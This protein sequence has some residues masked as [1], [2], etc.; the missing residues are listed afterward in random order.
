MIKTDK[1][2]VTVGNKEA[3]IIRIV[4]EKYR[5]DI[6]GKTAETMVEGLSNAKRKAKSYLKWRDI[7]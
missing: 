1:L 6:N 7:K 2:K 3:L 5:I 4:G